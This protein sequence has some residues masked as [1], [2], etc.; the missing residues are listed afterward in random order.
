[1][2]ILG[3]IA[4]SKLTAAP[5]SYESIA[6]VTVGSGGQANVEFT[7]IGSGYKH[8]QIRAIVRGTQ[9]VA[10]N[11]YQLQFNN[12]TASNYYGQHYLW[13]TGSSVAAGADGT[14]NVIYI[15]RSPAASATASIFGFQIIDILDY[16]STSKNK[17]V[18]Y[19][20][21]FDANG[22]GEV[23]IGS[24]LW[25]KTPEAITSIKLTPSANNFAEY[26]QFALY[27]IKD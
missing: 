21:G 11:Y 6:T 3:I 8:L 1:M 5:N 10:S 4:S 27:G 7:S 20:G 23:R 13:G 15:E 12:D 26:T 16:G 24:G 18:R 9:A 19:L 17:T 14:A 22:S 25:F 2:P